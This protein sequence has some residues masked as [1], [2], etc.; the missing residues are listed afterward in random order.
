MESPND[1]DVQL[2]DLEMK[3]QELIDKKESVEGRAL[4][5]QCKDFWRSPAGK[6]AFK[7]SIVLDGLK[8]G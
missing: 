6:K 3:K 2:E 1:I 5:E 4:I 7:N 8:D